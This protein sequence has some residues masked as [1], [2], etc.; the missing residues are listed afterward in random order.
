MGNCLSKLPKPDDL[1]YEDA[2]LE[3]RLR[4]TPFMRKFAYVVVRQPS[5]RPPPPLEFPPQSFEAPVQ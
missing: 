3:G 5:Y 4:L 1:I 2:L